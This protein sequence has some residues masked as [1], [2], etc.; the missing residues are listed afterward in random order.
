MTNTTSI[1]TASADNSGHDVI[2]SYRIQTDEE[3][4]GDETWDAL[5]DYADAHPAPAALVPFVDRHTPGDFTGVVVD[6]ATGEAAI[7]WLA[8]AAEALGWDERTTP[9]LVIPLADSTPPL[10]DALAAAIEA[11]EE[12]QSALDDYSDEH[13]YAGSGDERVEI[14]RL[15][16]LSSEAD[17][18]VEAARAAWL[19]S[20]EP[21]TYVESATPLADAFAAAVAAAAVAEHAWYDDDTSEDDACIGEHGPDC[22]HPTLVATRAADAAVEA[23]R[24]AWCAS[25][26]RRTYVIRYDDS[27]GVKS[28]VTC[29]PSEIDAA[30]EDEVRSGDWCDDGTVTYVDVK[31]TCDDGTD[32]CQTIVIQPEAPSC[33]DGHEHDWH[34][35]HEVVGGSTDNPGVQGHGG[36]VLIHEVCRHCG[37]HRHTDTWAQRRD[38]G[39]QGFR[40]VTY[41]E[42]DEESLSWASAAVRR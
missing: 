32:D 6:V 1:D 23:A 40:E 24:A 16:Q 2:R 15:G 5:H 21:R 4:G 18:A 27:S 14:D 26:E 22:R 36:G 28:E 17:V 8:T 35:P 30:V 25:D 39:E 33:A 7:T 19:A 38:T 9:V 41:S 34:S 13:G 29:A 42:P 37:A 11:A 12:A 10:A 3:T 20:D 31:V